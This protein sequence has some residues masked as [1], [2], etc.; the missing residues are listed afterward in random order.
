MDWA[1]AGKLLRVNL[2]NKSISIEERDEL[3]FRRY[4]GGVGLIAQILVKELGPKV[5]P[6]GP[7]NK[8]VFALGPLTG[9]PLAGTAR[10]AVGAKS[11]LSE[12]FGKGECGWFW[13]VE[14]RRAG[15]DAVIV[16]GRAKRP[17][18]LWVD[19]GKVEIRDAGHLWGLQTKECQAAIR[20]THRDNRVRVAQIGPGGENL[21]RFAC[22]IHDLHSAVGRTGMGAVMG[23][24]NLKAVAVRG[25]TPPKL[26]DPAGVR[27]IAK[28]LAKH[29]KVEAKMLHKL[30][31][32][33][34]MHESLETGNMPTRNWRD[35]AF[36]GTDN[37]S[38]QAI[39]DTIRIGMKGCWACPI[40]CKKVVQVKEPYTVDPAY[41]GPEY[42]T[43]AALGA[44]CG[45]DDL[46]AI[47]RAHHLCQANSLDTISTGSTIAFAMECFEKGLLTK[48]D[49]DGIELVFGN[50]EAMLETVE[51]IARRDGIGDLL[52][53]GS[54]RAAEQIGPE[55]QQ[56]AHQVKGVDMGMHEARLKPGTGLGYAVASHGGDH[57][58]GF[59]DTYF[60]GP[61]ARFEQAKPL[62]VIESLPASDLSP[63]KVAMF[64][65]LQRWQN[66]CDS[67]LMCV[68]IPFKP[69]QIMQAV[70][71]ATGWS[72][73]VWEGMKV[74]ERAITLAKAFNVIQ[75]LTPEEDRLPPRM[76]QPFARGP[77]KGVA[78]DP[79]E[80]ADAVRTY[81]KMMGWDPNT[82]IPTPEKLWEL[83]IE[84]VLDKI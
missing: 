79:K 36:E 56:Y 2:T 58:T 3:F 74:G 62:G 33:S 53:E 30:G 24:K 4:F 48:A 45:I 67:A 44:N 47:A 38:A 51:R 15:F 50:A 65:Y 29:Y 82:G 84:W 22:I 10:H 46:K 8:L 55:A 69:Q 20:A 6:L 9:A 40:R 81:Y 1:Y 77:L 49:T 64:S 39:R 71:N 60:Q 73:S 34:D 76:F 72:T 5:D 35:G 27:A 7:D 37:I 19:D 17:V 12:G 57:G 52:A 42:E 13:G 54:R 31:T 63:R 59:Q 43:L 21:V 14:L 11:P 66:L 23:S 18:Y 16:E 28:W 26:F 32:G 83:G 75:G 41:G 61:S 80:M 25:K 68:F 70:A 78:I